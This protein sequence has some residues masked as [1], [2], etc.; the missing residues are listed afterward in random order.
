MDYGARPEARPKARPVRFER[1][2][3]AKLCR[4]VVLTLPN[5]ATPSY[6]L[7]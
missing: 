1:E 4:A 2:A 5:A 6:Y 3:S 7:S